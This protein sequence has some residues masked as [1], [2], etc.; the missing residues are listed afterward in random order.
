MALA[1]GRRGA[2]EVPIIEEVK[3]EKFSVD[4]WREKA[5]LVN[6][7]L[8]GAQMLYLNNFTELLCK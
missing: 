1:K 5:N 3:I 8:I 6:E 4:L 7:L 2:K